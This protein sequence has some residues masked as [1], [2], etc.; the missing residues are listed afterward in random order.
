MVWVVFN[1]NWQRQEIFSSNLKWIND[2]DISTLLKYHLPYESKYGSYCSKS[3]IT[4]GF[5]VDWWMKT[6]KRQ[7]KDKAIYKFSPVNTSRL[8]IFWVSNSSKCHRWLGLFPRTL[9]GALR[10][11]PSPQFCR[12]EILSTATTAQ[13]NFLDQPLTNKI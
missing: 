12:Q 5:T 11:P 9:F 13:S 8:S 1:R 10:L 4:I 3:E 7:C 2:E 6:S